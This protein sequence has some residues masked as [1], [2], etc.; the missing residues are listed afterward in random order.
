MAVDPARIIE[1]CSPG[2]LPVA[3]SDR[4]RSTLAQAI[5]ITPRLRRCHSRWIEGLLERVYLS[6][7]HVNRQGNGEFIALANARTHVPGAV[8][9]YRRRFLGL[10]GHLPIVIPAISRIDPFSKVEFQKTSRK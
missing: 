5:R 3:R 10:N 4:L 8:N 6:P 1:N 7:N 2:A 9:K